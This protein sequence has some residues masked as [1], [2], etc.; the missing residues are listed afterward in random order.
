[1]NN[2]FEHRKNSLVEEDKWDKHIL[3][4]LTFQ[5]QLISKKII[6]VQHILYIIMILNKF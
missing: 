6:I 4:S 2:I 5:I 3:V 1:M